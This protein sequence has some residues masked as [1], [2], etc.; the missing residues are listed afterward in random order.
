MVKTTTKKQ[1][2]EIESIAMQ[3]SNTKYKEK[4]TKTSE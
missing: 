2:N 4:K 3:L 1:I